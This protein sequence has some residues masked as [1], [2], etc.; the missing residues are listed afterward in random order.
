MTDDALNDILRRA[1]QTRGNAGIGSATAAEAD[2]LGHAWVGPGYSTGRTGT[3]LISA[4]RLRQ[5]RPPTRKPSWQGGV[6]QANFQSRE[7]PRGFWSNNA[8]LDITDLT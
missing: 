1:A 4:D 5:Y 7:E 8:H 2:A 3:I 6:V